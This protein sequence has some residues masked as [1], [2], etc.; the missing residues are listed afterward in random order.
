MPKIKP[1]EETKCKETVFFIRT[2]GN[3]HSVFY[4]KGAQV[5]VTFVEV[6]RFAYGFK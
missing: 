2:N 6:H 3:D 1:N 4:M 5:K